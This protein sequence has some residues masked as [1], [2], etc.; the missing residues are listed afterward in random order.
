MVILDESTAEAGSADADQLERA[1]RAVGEGR[2]VLLIAHRLTQAAQ[3]DR[4]IVME[5]GRITEQGTH[6][7]LLEAGNAYARLWS[8]WAENR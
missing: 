1:A 2:A 4:V 5:R 7:E 3:A 6:A 8:V